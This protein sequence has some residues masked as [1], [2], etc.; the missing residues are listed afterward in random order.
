MET[1]VKI[2]PPISFA[3][4]VELL[5]LNEQL[6]WNQIFFTIHRIYLHSAA[7]IYVK[8]SRVRLVFRLVW[9]LLNA[10]WHPFRCAFFLTFIALIY[11]DVFFPP[12]FYSFFFSRLNEFCLFLDRCSV[13]PRKNVQN[14]SVIQ[15]VASLNH[16]L[17]IGKWKNDSR[18]RIHILTVSN[19]IFQFSFPAARTQTQTINCNASQWLKHIYSLYTKSIFSFECE[20]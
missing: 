15:D 3:E 12:F 5:L 6:A 20:Q 19:L 11:V 1:I 13:T 2:D 14:N 17:F 18:R 9:S 10:V 4:Y 16:D 7:W 8:V